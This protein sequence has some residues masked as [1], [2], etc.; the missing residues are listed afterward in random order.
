MKGEVEILKFNPMIF[1]GACPKSGTSSEVVFLVLNT[2]TAEGRYSDI[3]MLNDG[4]SLL[5]S[6]K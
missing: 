3:C 2:V 5:V 4:R 1:L 6:D